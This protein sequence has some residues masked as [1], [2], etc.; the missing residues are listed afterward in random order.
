MKKII[1]FLLLV[2]VLTFVLQIQAQVAVNH[3]GTDPA[4]HTILHVK[5][6]GE[7]PFVIQDADGKTGIGLLNPQRVLDIQVNAQ[8]G[9][10]GY[11]GLKVFRENL[12]GGGMHFMRARGTSDNPGALRKNDLLAYFSF[13]GY[14][15]GGFHQGAHFR[16]YVDEEVTGSNIPTGMMMFLMDKEG[17]ILPRLT[18]RSSGKVGIGT[19]SPGARLHVKDVFNKNELQKGIY[20]DVFANPE[21]GNDAYYIL[22]HQI[23]RTDPGNSANIGKI[24]ATN[25][26]VD[27]KGSGMVS[28]LI[29]TVNAVNVRDT[30]EVD[31]LFPTSNTVNLYNNAHVK[32]LHGLYNGISVRDNAVVDNVYGSATMINLNSGT[33]NPSSNIWTAK[34][35]VSVQGSGEYGIVSG[36]MDLITHQNPDSLGRAYGGQNIVRNMPGAGPVGFVFGNY[37]SAENASDSNISN[38]YVSFNQFR[39]TGNGGVTQNGFVNMNTFSNTAGGHIKTMT[40]VYAV[41]NNEGDGQVD[42]WYGNRIVFNNK[43]T[44]SKAGNIFGIHAQLNNKSEEDVNQY[45]A[46]VH[47]VTNQPGAGDISLVKL[48]QNTFTHQSESTVATVNG[49]YSLVQNTGGGT[50]NVIYGLRSRLVNSSGSVNRWYGLYIDPLAENSQYYGIFVGRGNKSYFGGKVGIGITMP[51][52]EL[53]LDGVMHLRPRSTEP[54]NPQDGDLYMDDG[55]HTSDGT[56]KVRVYANGSWHELW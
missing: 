46:S 28:S 32:R 7:V 52:R 21:A 51:T 19:S 42:T 10:D 9:N 37:T 45:T 23:F 30:R 16:F 2:P 13:L 44:R 49:V 8:N 5:G 6:S 55:T 34:N 27:V 35:S 56:P 1:K 53:S 40:N 36:T 4:P 12:Y 14:S 3:D 15:E 50:V 11:I 18:V 29:G 43:G 54:S 48:S 22:H 17:N 33:T 31:G 38:L 47:G 39:N 26:V 41:G 20:T 25:N 24:H